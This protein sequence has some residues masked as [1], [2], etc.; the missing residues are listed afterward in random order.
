MRSC[1]GIITTKLFTSTH[2]HTLWILCT[3]HCTLYT[4]NRNST[5][6]RFVQIEIL[7]F[8]R[9]D[10]VGIS[11]SSHLQ[12]AECAKDLGL[13]SPCGQVREFRD[14]VFEDVGFGNNR[15]LTLNNWRCGTSHLKL[16]WVK[17]FEHSILKPHILKHHIPEPPN[18]A[19]LGRVFVP[20]R[21]GIEAPGASPSLAG[22]RPTYR[23]I[24]IYIYVCIHTYMYMYLKRHIPKRHPWTPNRCSALQTGPRAAAIYYNS[25]TTLLE[26]SIS[27]RVE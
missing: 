15:L 19:V 25:A 21:Y 11:C 7:C 20:A 1:N 24:Y 2:T 13:E 3:I 16:I 4:D 5:R 12:G 26:Q 8:C 27:S 6:G 17:G 18:K 22:K 23:S 9:L 14:V 10:S